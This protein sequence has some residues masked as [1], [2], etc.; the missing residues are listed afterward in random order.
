MG[1][2]FQV[3]T[4]CMCTDSGIELHIFRAQAE[5]MASDSVLEQLDEV[6]GLKSPL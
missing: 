3:P 5:V 6:G 1:E 2:L 4:T